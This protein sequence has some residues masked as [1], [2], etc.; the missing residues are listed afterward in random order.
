MYFDLYS[1][2]I[3][4]SASKLRWQMKGVNGKILLQLKVSKQENKV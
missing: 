4:S 1:T 3:Y 2:V